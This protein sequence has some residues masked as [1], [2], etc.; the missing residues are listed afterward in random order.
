MVM[1]KR[2][3]LRLAYINQENVVQLLWAND[4]LIIGNR[5]MKYHSSL[6]LK[7]KKKCKPSRLAM[8]RSK[9]HGSNKQGKKGY[10]FDRNFKNNLS[11]VSWANHLFGIG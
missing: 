8:L 7:K 2:V 10:I 11:K 1:Q 6:E 3:T 9:S 4:Q 5:V